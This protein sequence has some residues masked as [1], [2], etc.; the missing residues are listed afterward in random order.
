MKLTS[1]VLTA[2]LLLTPGCRGD[3]DRSGTGVTDR[4]SA[5]ITIVQ[6]AAVPATLEA[7]V[8]S[9]PV[10]TIGGEA[11]GPD[12]DLNEIRGSVRLSDGRIVVADNLT[13]E[14]RFFDS[15]GAFLR[16]GGRKGRG[17]GEFEQI[18]NLWARPGDTVAVY[19]AATRR[20]SFFS[21]GG[22]FVRQVD[23][24]QAG[25]VT[26]TA[27]LDDGTVVGGGFSFNPD[28]LPPKGA[29]RRNV[30]PVLLIAPDGT[31]TDTMATF[32]GMEMYTVETNIQGRAFPLPLQVQFGLNTSLGARGSQV[33]VGDNARP[34]IRVYGRDGALQKIIRASYAPVTVTEADRTAQAEQ[35]LE[36]WAASPLRGMPRQMME[37]IEGWIRNA[38]Y[39][40]RF[41]PY[42]TFRLDGAGNIWVQEFAP[43]RPQQFQVYGPGGEFVVHAVLPP[44]VRP[45]DVGRDYM[46]A[47]WKDA[48]GL[49]HVRVYRT[50]GLAPDETAR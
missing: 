35:N 8:D 37:Q 43:G 42:E 11:R 6:N 34:E 24:G 29:R 33:Y 50:A 7:V 3:P 27:L 20:I 31:G 21:P 18:L 1:L 5:G 40:D 41:P 36:R 10:F 32:E 14:L 26:P 47:A 12:Y 48:D 25:F 39:A 38:T 17:P 28:S 44:D 16:R 19:D 23:L 4:D 13:G 9:V 30:L 22:V 45:L 49:E 2:S 46:V 15:T